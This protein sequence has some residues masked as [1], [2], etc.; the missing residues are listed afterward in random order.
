MRKLLQDV[1]AIIRDIPENEGILVFV[2]KERNKRD[3]KRALDLELRKVGIE[4]EDKPTLPTGQP[5]ISVETW[6]CETSLNEYRYCKHVILVGILHR[7]MT[8]LEAQQLGQLNDLHRKVDAGDLKAIA[9]SERAHLAYQALS[10]G[11]CRVLDQPGQARAMTGY[12]V[13]YDEEI[14]NELSKVMPG[15]TWKTW[16]PLYSD[17]VAHGK[18]VHDL[19]KDV[20]Q[21]LD[22]LPHETF[23]VS[24][25][26]LR[27]DLKA[28][29]VAKMTWNRAV[30]QAC[31]INP[32]WNQRGQSLI[33]SLETVPIQ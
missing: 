25:R 14:E 20:A 1:S 24:S 18:T 29:R 17:P 27:S 30:K 11:A 16:T 9:L 7:D 32:Q 21:C 3:M 23:K 26:R 5:R 13:E 12:I 22:Q 28:E 15:V 31:V 6:G 2:Y 33:R 4:L 10:R 19:A 8:E